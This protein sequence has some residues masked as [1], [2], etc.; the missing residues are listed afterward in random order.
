ML[1]CTIT[2]GKGAFR[3]YT[4]ATRTISM[5]A[6][7]TVT[8]TVSEEKIREI[9]HQLWVDAGQPEGQAESHWFH[10]LEMAS[11]KAKKSAAKPAEKVAAK[12]VVAAK[13]AKVVAKK[14][15]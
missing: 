9:A 1:Q 8:A 15:K 14:S 12:P 3:E 4:H 6:A 10:A 2:C 7:K 5:A 13:P 11:A